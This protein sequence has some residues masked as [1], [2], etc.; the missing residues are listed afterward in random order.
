MVARCDHSINMSRLVKISE[1][2]IHNTIIFLRGKR[3]IIDS[4]LAEFYGSTTKRLNEQI[5]RN[6]KRFPKDF[7]FRLTKKEKGYVIANCDHL[8]KIKF[9]P[10]L[11]LAFTEY[12]AVMTATILSSDIA[13]LASVQIVRSFIKIS[14]ILATHKELANKIEKLEHTM[15]SRLSKHD[16]EIH[17]LFEAIKQL[18]E[19]V[20]PPRKKIGYKI[21]NDK[22]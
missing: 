16:K 5:K 1:A 21:G 22:A 15:E 14:E 17:I 18:M 20:N 3:V 19:P 13:I 8:K 10:H 4:D 9:S 12:G 6:I 11:P 2:Q 7:M